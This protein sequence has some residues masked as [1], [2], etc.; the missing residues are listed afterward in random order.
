M[1]THCG[2][3]LHLAFHNTYGQTDDYGD[4]LV[5]RIEQTYLGVFAFGLEEYCRFEPNIVINNTPHALLSILVLYTF[6]QG[7]G[8]AFMK[9]K[10]LFA[11]WFLST[12]YFFIRAKIDW[13][14][15]I[16][17]WSLAIHA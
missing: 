2:T 12:K 6:W 5:L 15:Q 11:G 4:L 14:Y 3:C 16:C 8:K 17:L 7:A 13:L 9:H 1:Y 10:C